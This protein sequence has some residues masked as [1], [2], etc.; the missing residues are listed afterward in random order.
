MRDERRE[1]RAARRGVPGVAGVPAAAG[2]DPGGA[3]PGVAGRTAGDPARLRRRDRA[4]ACGPHAGVRRG[5]AAR[6]DPGTGRLPRGSPGGSPGRP[7]GG[8][9]VKSIRGLP[10]ALLL[11]GPL[12][13]PLLALLAYEGYIVY[14]LTAGPSLIFSVTLVLAPLPSSAASRAPRGDTATISRYS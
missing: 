10:A 2:Q 12:L 11:L 3:V 13:G 1:A 14:Q 5:H 6:G 9:P 8:G 7:H 4:A